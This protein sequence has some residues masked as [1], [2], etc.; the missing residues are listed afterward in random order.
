MDNTALLVGGV[1]ALGIGYV[2]WKKAQM[3]ALPAT[4]AIAANPTP[5]YNIPSDLLG[6]MQ[7][8]WQT[9]ALNPGSN[10]NLWISAMQGVVPA[11]QS[12]WR[13]VYNQ[14]VAVIA[15][16]GGNWPTNSQLTGWLQ[17]GIQNYT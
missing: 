14:W 11:S 1:A 9:A 2:L 3:P 10:A 7:R 17:Q 4:P 12:A 16:T 5:G 13:Y 6:T 8:A 15:T